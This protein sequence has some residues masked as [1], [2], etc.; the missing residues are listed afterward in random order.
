MTSPG[1]A[2]ISALVAAFLISATA[3]TQQNVVVAV[4]A[5]AGAVDGMTENS[6]ALIWRLFTEFV[7]P[8]SKGR[9]SPV[10]FETWA[11]DDDTFS[12]KPHWPEPSATL[13]ADAA[14]SALCGYMAWIALAGLAVNAIWGKS[15]ADPLAASALAPLILR[16]GWE[17]FKSSKLCCD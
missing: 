10:M 15:W 2:I 11:S 14:E 13:K 12:A 17:A 9:S 5:K 3:W 16:E 6:D 8:A 1:S 4:P 7:A